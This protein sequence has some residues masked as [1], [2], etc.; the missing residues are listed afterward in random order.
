[1]KIEILNKNTMFPILISDNWYSNEEEKNVWLELDFIHSLNEYENSEE[2]SAYDKD[3]ISKSKAKRLYYE[4][5]F[6]EKKYSHICKMLYKIKDSSLH[7]IVE[8]SM[9]IGKIFKH[10]DWDNT[11]LNYYE[12]ND[13]YKSHYD[14][15]LFTMLIFFHKKPKLFSG[16]DLYFE[17]SNTTVEFKHNRMVLF[18][19]HYLHQANKVSMNSEYQNKMNGRFTITHFIS[20][21][22]NNV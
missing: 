9:P 7:D 13:N 5:V 21:D 17:E 15:S 22:I 19:G 3:K 16:G 10:T 11:F 20:K 8:K 14:Y 2:N 6:R 12:N 4:L 1:M 18:P